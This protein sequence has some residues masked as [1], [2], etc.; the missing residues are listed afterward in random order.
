MKSKAG[1]IL[2]VLVLT[3]CTMGVSPARAA[4]APAVTAPPV[5]ASTS[6]VPGESAS[7]SLLC[8]LDL[9]AVPAPFKTAFVPP[10]CG[11]CSDFVCQTRSVGA[12]C[13]SDPVTH[14]DKHCYDF[15]SVCQP[16]T[17]AQC[18]C[19]VNIP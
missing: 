16:T 11:S 12:V 14:K 6:T 8:S 5:A 7:S 3:L 13:G 15:D 17:D 1:L 19:R 2:G 10:V 4:V 18:R 9:S